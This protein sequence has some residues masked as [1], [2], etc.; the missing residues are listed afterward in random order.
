MKSAAL[1]AKKSIEFLNT[2]QSL[3]VHHIRT[4]YTWSFS[5]FSLFLIPSSG[6]ADEK[7]GLGSSRNSRSRKCSRSLIPHEF[8]VF[9]S[10]RYS[11]RL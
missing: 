6:A 3:K 11:L 10:P 8:N 4:G 7:D 9:F 1:N 5:F 2:M